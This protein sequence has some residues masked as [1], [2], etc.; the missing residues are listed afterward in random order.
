MESQGKAWLPPRFCEQTT[1]LITTTLNQMT[2]HQW[3]LLM[4][5]R[6][7]DGYR[8]NLCELLVDI[9]TN[10]CRTITSFRSENTSVYKE[11]VECNVGDTVMKSFIDALNIPDQV[12]SVSAKCLSNLL[13]KEVSLSVDSTLSSSRSSVSSV[14]SSRVT[15]P[16]TLNT[17]IN[18]VISMFK[19][20][21][22]VKRIRDE[23]L[24]LTKGDYQQGCSSGE[25]ASNEDNI[26]SE[27]NDMLGSI[28]D[29]SSS[30]ERFQS[31]MSQE[32]ED[33]YEKI[34][35]AFVGYSQV[36]KKKYRTEVMKKVQ[37]I[38][39]RRS[40]KFWIR[41]ILAKLRG[42]FLKKSNEE[43]HEMIQPIVEMVES[44][45]ELEKDQVGEEI[46]ALPWTTNA[47]RV[48]TMTQELTD[49]LQ[50]NLVGEVVA[51]EKVA[52]KTRIVIS[53]NASAFMCLLNWWASTQAKR[54]SKRATQMLTQHAS[55]SPTCQE[56]C[57]LQ[58]QQEK[59]KAFV[60]IL[61]DK[62]AWQLFRKLNIVPNNKNDIMLTL[63]ENTWAAVEGV[64][65]YICRK[66]M[67]S[68][69]TIVHQMCKQHGGAQQVVME[70]REKDPETEKHLSSI[71]VGHLT[72]KPSVLSVFGKFWVSLLSFWR[73][74][75][76]YIQ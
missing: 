21:A 76:V 33:T 59:K 37:A 62:V 58:V 18:Y 6:L 69:R 47:D 2:E 56:S 70:L 52:H 13:N 5:G 42:K 72:K 48:V 26:K 4:S 1:Q 11:Y 9:I 7:D 17:M 15:P 3:N 71:V 34:T 55:A 57:D 63:F 16:N 35:K 10:A 38:L 46:S 23:K 50:V 49:L 75:T 43:N 45:L 27:L 28:W 40:A 22:K 41:R 30:S 73:K 14:I 39:M 66:T 29:D 44:M 61:T 25:W 51:I 24:R 64:D 65:L 60:G 68:H 36:P 67:R 54:H 53:T 32:I 12:E 19:R 8:I 74:N 20:S 31:E